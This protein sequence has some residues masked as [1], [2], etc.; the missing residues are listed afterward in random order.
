MSP[1]W[2]L[3]SFVYKGR[4]R[5]GWPVYRNWHLFM[6]TGGKIVKT[7]INPIQMV[8]CNTPECKNY[9]SKIHDELI[10]N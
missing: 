4:K 9:K 5:R 7:D 6:R 3:S 1:R 10:P 2:Y 8:E